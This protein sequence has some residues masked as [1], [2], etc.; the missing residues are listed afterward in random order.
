MDLAANSHR[1]PREILERIGD[2]PV[3]GIFEWHETVVR[4]PFMDFLE[5]RTDGSHRQKINGLAEAVDGGQVTVAVEWA[6]ERDAV[7]FL[8]RPRPADDFPEDRTYTRFA[9]GTF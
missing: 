4:G 6:E 2:S 9:D 1:E 3:G 8:D 7:R 5:D